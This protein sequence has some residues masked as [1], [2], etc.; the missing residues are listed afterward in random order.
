MKSEG[1]A[2]AGRPERHFGGLGVSAGIAVGPAHVVERGLIDVPEYRIEDAAVEAE[3]ARFHEAVA[4]S[5]AQIRTL[6]AKAEAL[7]EEVAGQLRHLLDAHLLMLSG[8]RLV[9]GVEARIRD[10]GINAEAA[11]QVQL[12]EI[13]Q[14]FAGMED[15]YLAGKIDDVREASGRLVRNLTRAGYQAF[16]GLPP[17]TIVIAE[18]VTPADTALMDPARIGGFAAA[19]GG[20]EGHTAIMARSLGLPAVLGVA[21]L[22]G[23]VRSGDIVAVDGVRGGL[24][25]NPGEA[26]IARLGA[27]APRAGAARAPARPAAPGRSRIERR[28]TGDPAMQYRAAQRAAAGAGGRRRGHRSAAQRVPLHEPRRAAE[29]GRAVCRAQGDRGGDGGRAGDGAHPGRGLGQARL[30]PRRAHHAERQSGAGLARRPPLAQD[31]GAAGG[32]DRGRSPGRRPRAGAHPGAHDHLGRRDQAC[33]EG[34]G[35]DG[36]PPDARPRGDRGRGRRSAS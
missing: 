13:A 16:S 17:G 6:Q 23:A 31:A 32:A 2:T 18:E 7:P 29:R 9:R 28:R 20:A 25:V 36:P 35:Q 5:A 14:A 19:L 24:V 22:V 34:R 33:A 30:L 10:A 21:G 26:T 3:I 8:S 15:S 27:P 4:L 12:S 1:K 11:V